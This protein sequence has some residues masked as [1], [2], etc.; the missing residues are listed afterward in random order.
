MALANGVLG[1][2][3]NSAFS[4][5]DGAP[6]T[7]AE[8]GYSRWG[9]TSGLLCVDLCVLVCESGVCEGKNSHQYS[10][11]LAPPHPPV[12]QGR[13][14]SLRQLSGSSTSRA[15]LSTAEQAEHSHTLAED[16][17]GFRTTS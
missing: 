4:G 13:L 2:H 6:L 14:L 12:P 10:Q 11:L 16:T 9:T 1:W 8:G 5:R 3:R 17:F 15:F 7:M